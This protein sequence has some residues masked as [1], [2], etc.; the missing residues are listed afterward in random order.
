[1][2][3]DIMNR[4]KIR[5]TELGYSFQELADKTGL[6]KSTLQ[7]YETGAIDKLPIEKA[8][9]IAEALQMPV[10]RLL[11]FDLPAENV[12]D[13]DNVFN[14]P[15][16]DSVSAGFGAYPD[17]SA[18]GYKPSYIANASEAGEYLWINVKGDSMSPK[19]EDGDKILVRR[20]D[21]V[22]NGAV[23]V[24]MVDDEAVVKI[25]KY[26]LN[27]VELH[28]INPHYPVRRFEKQ[29]ALRISVVGRVKEVCK[30]L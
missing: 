2:K 8:S 26:G 9:L 5:R 6:S 13:I 24:V 12:C 25:I 1:M 30:R 21:S 19:I 14:I 7:R 28:S 15:V 11:G 18:V 17:S 3:K 16:Y 10:E 20:Q 23:A 27:W 4:M 29:E 22:D